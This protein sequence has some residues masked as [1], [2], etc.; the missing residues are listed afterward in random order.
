MITG[1]KCNITCSSDRQLH[2]GGAEASKGD[3]EEDSAKVFN[4]FKKKNYSQNT[5]HF[6]KLYLKVFFIS[7]RKLHA[8]GSIEDE[9]L[10]EQ[11]LFYEKSLKVLFHN[12]C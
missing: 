11:D 7:R 10:P 1:E 2:Q 3:A 4:R 5:A 9:S 12:F 8:I 6:V